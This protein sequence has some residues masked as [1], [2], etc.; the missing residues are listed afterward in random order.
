P[1]L[2][3][4][5][6]K[7]LEK[8]AAQAFKNEHRYIG[9]EHLLYALVESTAD[10]VLNLLVTQKKSLNNI[11]EEIEN[12]LS[13]IA[14]FPEMSALIGGGQMGSPE[15]LPNTFA[16]AIPNKSKNKKTPALDYFTTNLTNPKFLKTM[17][18]IIGRAKE[19]QR[20][21]QILSR[22]QKNNPVLLGDPGVGKTAIVEG[23]AQKIITGDVPDELQNKKLLRLDLG[24]LIAGTIY[25]GEFEGRLKQLMDEI[26]NDPNIIVFIDEMHT[27][28]GAGSASGTLDAA[29]I[30]KPALAR[31]EM[32]CIGATTFEEYKKHIESDPAL[33]RRFQPI[34]VNEPSA[35][36][37]IQILTGVAKNY[38]AFHGVDIS[39]SAIVAAVKLA[40]RQYPEKF[41]PD[42]ALDLLDEAA[43]A[44]KLSDK[45]KTW[46]KKIR[47]IE[48]KIKELQE[49]KYEAVAKETF[50]LAAKLKKEEETCAKQ[51]LD[52]QKQNINQKTKK[53][54]ILD[55]EDIKN[56]LSQSFGLNII[57]DEDS[58]E[59]FEK[60]ANQIKSQIIGQ[61]E[62]IEK[63][64]NT[65]KKTQLGLRDPNRPI[66]SFLFVGPSGVGKTALA[67]IL[68]K[69]YFGELQG[70]SNFIRIDMSEFG[71]SFQATKLIGAPAGYV[72]Y[73]ESNSLA[74]KIK[75]HPYSVI[76]LDEIDK[77]H[78]D[79][80]NLFLQILDEG[81]LTDASG[82]K[83]NF[84]NTIIIMTANL[85]D[86]MLKKGTMGFG[87]VGIK[88]K[89]E[90]A[91][92]KLSEEIKNKFRAD[93]LN[94]IDQ[95]LFFHPLQ[96]QDL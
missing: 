81:R 79:I 30:L 85:G 60:I 58:N 22:R 20:L 49:Q 50:A 10:S 72:G 34:I 94:R 47:T 53:K 5:S 29:N 77:A 12:V 2:S 86:D 69:S 24:L 23:L 83:I 62:V 11:K 63:I 6:E 41:F 93:F 15:A 92:K 28:V 89:Y 82:K 4:E 90:E 35:E 73:K 39:P 56:L 68:A 52:L 45:N 25:R 8:A 32:R 19:T 61:D 40:E 9:T 88:K 95:I 84:K 70:R 21:I 31:G 87:D 42:K 66:A 37:T 3:K 96:T 91:D 36:E 1:R 57:Q 33:D 71:E 27:I 16:P 67:K 75:N 76:L 65:L 54:L 74:D 43:A 59:H 44:K 13:S 46:L 38:A 14:R 51:I 7:L 55:A 26:K 48:N 64:I 18:P 80:F 17:D 78:P